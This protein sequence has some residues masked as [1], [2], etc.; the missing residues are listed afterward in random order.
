MIGAAA[1][2]Q[3]EAGLATRDIIG[4]AEGILMHWMDLTR[5]QAFRLLTRLSQKS[6]TKLVEIA[7]LVVEHHRSKVKPANS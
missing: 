4:E 1:E 3:F 7:R 5:L 2:S 6:D